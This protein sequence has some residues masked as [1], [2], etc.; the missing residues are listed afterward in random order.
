MS[1]PVDFNFCLVSKVQSVLKG[2][3]LGTGFCLLQEFCIG[4]LS[5]GW[6]CWSVCAVKKKKKKALSLQLSFVYVPAVV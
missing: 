1:A 5:L 3:L 6:L 4:I 2:K